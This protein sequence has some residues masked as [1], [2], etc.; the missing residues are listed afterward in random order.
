MENL[1]PSSW[2]TTLLDTHSLA[3]D[4]SYL[5]SPYVEDVSKLA[6]HAYLAP[7]TAY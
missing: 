3:E 5:I 7:A 6:A 4:A 1:F 2:N